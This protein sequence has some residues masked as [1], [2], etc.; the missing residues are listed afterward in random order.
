MTITDIQLNPN[1]AKEHPDWHIDKIADS[2]RAFGC[3]Q[4]IVIDSKGMIVAGHGRFLAMKNKL[5]Y[6]N[7]EE[8]SHTKK[9]EAVIPY[10]LA[11]DLTDE[12]LKAYRYADNQINSMTGI[13]LSKAIP[14]LRELSDD[15]F[16]LTGFDKDLIV[17]ADEMDERT[18]GTPNIPRT[19]T[20]DIY[21]LGKHR[22]MCGSSLEEA[23]MDELFDGAFAR[24]CFT[25]PPYNMGNKGMYNKYED[26]LESNEY[27]DFNLNVIKNVE[28]FINGFLFWNISYNKNSR[29]EWIEIYHRIITQTKFNFLESIVWDKGHGMPIVGG[30]GLTRQ[31]ESI[32][33]VGDE[34][35]QAEM[36]RAFIG[37]NN[38]EVYSNKKSQKKL[39][40][41]WKISSNNSQTE[42]NK[43]CF[44]VALPL[45]GILIMTGEGDIVL[46]PFM[47]TGSTLIAAEKTGRVAYGMELDP[48]YVDVI[49]ERWCQYTNKRAITLNGEDIVWE[50]L[51]S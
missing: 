5:G 51:N 34:S 47:G 7:L 2:I 43:A 24:L 1:N 45:K 36:D 30:D 4:P 9:G 37:S 19:K 28:K 29:K 32:L 40:N 49:V 10:L 11:D 17:E 46:D 31:Y 39:T 20:G 22:I 26:N 18:P 12:K 25:S 44:P 21:Q 23:D 3:K 35:G 33:A 15:M 14:E 50:P 6:V 13:D 16:N 38:Q 8:K 27:I 41:Y 48:R 42:I